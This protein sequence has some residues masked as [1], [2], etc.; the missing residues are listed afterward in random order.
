MSMS[1]KEAIR[2]ARVAVRE[3][4]ASMPELLDLGER[5]DEH[6]TI[7]LRSYIE[8]RG[9]VLVPKVP[10]PKMVDDARDAHEGEHYLPYSL[11]TA[12]IAAAPDPFAIDTEEGK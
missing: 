8:A 5:Y 7:F 11:Y 1:H 3:H 12:M 10:T 6:D 2:E 4:I 9:L